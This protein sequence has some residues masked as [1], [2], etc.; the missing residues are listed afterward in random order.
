MGY[1]EAYECGEETNITKSLTNPHY[2]FPIT[3]GGFKEGTC[4]D[5][6][7]PIFD[8][9]EVVDMH[10]LP[11]TVPTSTKDRHCVCPH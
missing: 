4:A 8:R 10:P 2:F 11:G 7:Y 3:F 1:P 6:G 5:A 9:S